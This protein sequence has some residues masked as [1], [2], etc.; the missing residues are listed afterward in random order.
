[1]KVFIKQLRSNPTIT[2]LKSVKASYMFTER[3][4]HSIQ[5]EQTNSVYLIAISEFRKEMGPSV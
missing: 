2:N 4:Y 5:H 3:T 1:M